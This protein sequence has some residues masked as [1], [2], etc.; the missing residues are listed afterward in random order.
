M[1]ECAQYNREPLPLPTCN[2]FS[3][4]L[5]QSKQ[6]DNIAASVSERE[7]VLFLDLNVLHDKEGNLKADEYQVSVGDIKSKWET[8]VPNAINISE[9]ATLNEISEGN[10]SIQIQF[11]NTSENPIIE[12]SIVTAVIVDSNENKPKSKLWFQ[13]CLKNSY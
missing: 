9:Y 10:K 13:M 4:V 2:G 6:L 5:E 12:S 3:I 1:L 7:N 11:R 8:I